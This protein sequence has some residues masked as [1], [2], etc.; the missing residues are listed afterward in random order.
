MKLVI[1]RGSPYR[2]GNSD[3][4]ADE[5]LKGCDEGVSVL[6]DVALSDISVESCRSCRVC[7]REGECVIGDDATV[8]YGTLWEVDVLVVASC[9]HFGGLPSKMVALLERAQPCWVRWRLFNTPPSRLTEAGGLRRGYILLTGGSGRRSVGCPAITILR[10][11]FITLGFTPTALLYASGY[12]SHGEVSSDGR[13]LRKAFLLG[14]S[15]KMP[16]MDLERG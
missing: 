5:F 15:L 9:I 13:L 6:R 7:E 16:S 1:L 4:L 14:Q 10:N 11:W 12:D 2:D 8:F 3:I